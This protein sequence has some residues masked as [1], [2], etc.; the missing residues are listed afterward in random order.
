MKYAI[1]LIVCASMV[2]V[3]V[4]NVSGIT[5]RHDR[6]D[7]QYTS[8]ATSVFPQAGYITGP[9]WIGSGTLISPTWVLTA[10]HVAD[11]S[12]TT[13][14]SPAGSSSIINKYVWGGGDLGLVQL[15]TPITSQDPIRL[16]D[17]LAFGDE[18]GQ[19][20]MLAGVGNTGTG[21]TG[22]QGGTAGTYR[23]AETDVYANA[24]AWGWGSHQL[25]T[26]FRSPTGGADNLEGGSTQG[27][28]GGG[29]FLNVGGEWAIAGVLSLAWYT[30]GSENIGKYDSGGVFVRSGTDPVLDW[31]LSYATDAQVVPEPAALSALALGAVFIRRFRRVA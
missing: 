9:G 12:A 25:L 4:S 24:D 28:S 21:L 29:I 6:S 22:Q 27:D 3:V 1:R 16:Y 26:Y 5:T 10:G 8:L 17:V 7:S 18:V 11:P 31:I 30:G 14:G 20:A 15:A 23:A 13:F 2:G 19:Q